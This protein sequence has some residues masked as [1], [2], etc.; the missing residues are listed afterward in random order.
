MLV[1]TIDRAA[2]RT[3][4]T[5]LLASAQPLPATQP[6]VANGIYAL[7]IDA[8]RVPALERAVRMMAPMRREQLAFGPRAMEVFRAPPTTRGDALELDTGLLALDG[9]ALRLL[10][11]AWPVP[12]QSDSAAAT[13]IDLM[14]QLVDSRGPSPGALSPAAATAIQSRNARGTLLLRL[15]LEAELPAG[16]ALVL[17][18]AGLAPTPAAAATTTSPG[19]SDEEPLPALPPAPV[20]GPPVPRLPN[21][22]DAMLREAF[23]LP[24][25]T[26]ATMLVLVPKPPATFTILPAR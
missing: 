17:V 19:T 5:S 7:V 8:D 15:R 1:W 14:P 23:V 10:A 11:R 16:K 22:G 2:D 3:V 9:D 25:H 21:L 12:S 6:L 13:A 24:E 20:A 26:R 4:L 18:P